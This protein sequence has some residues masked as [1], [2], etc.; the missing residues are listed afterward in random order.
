MTKIQ[1]P[2]CK[3]SNAEIKKIDDYKM[4]IWFHCPICGYIAIMD[5]QLNKHSY[6]NYH[7][8]NKLI[9]V[10][11]KMS[12]EN[13]YIELNYDELDQIANS[14]DYPETIE[15]KTDL[16]LEYIIENEDGLNTG[17]AV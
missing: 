16:L 7:Q 12:N 1:C 15:Q 14:V 4:K 17:C 11:R 13:N 3:N 8:L 5:Y 9:Y 2:L 10:I 6:H